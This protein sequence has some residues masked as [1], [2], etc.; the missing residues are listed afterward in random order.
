MQ[1]GKTDDYKPVEA[2]IP[3][4]RGSVI[5]MSKS[6]HTALYANNSHRDSPMKF[7]KENN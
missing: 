2:I 7:V 6:S 5:S 1:V 4:D 3:P